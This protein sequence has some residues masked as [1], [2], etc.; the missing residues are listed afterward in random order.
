MMLETAPAA[1]A[2]RALFVGR[3]RMGATILRWLTIIL[4]VIRNILVIPAKAGISMPLRTACRRREIPAGVY[5][6]LRR[7]AGM[8]TEGRRA[9]RCEGFGSAAAPS[10]VI[11]RNLRWYRR[12]SH[13][14]KRVSVAF[15]PNSP[16]LSRWLRNAGSPPTGFPGG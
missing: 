8:T 16:N 13:A 12:R 10:T 15:A 4:H 14:R 9:V 6:E 2:G 3:R 5:P 1:D 11:H 7:R